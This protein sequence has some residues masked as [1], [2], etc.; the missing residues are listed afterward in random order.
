MYKKQS[1]DNLFQNPMFWIVAIGILIVVVSLKDED[2]VDES[3]MEMVIPNIP[4]TTFNYETCP[5]CGGTGLHYDMESSCYRCLGA[6]VVVVENKSRNIPF[7]G[8]KVDDDDYN[9]KQAEKYRKEAEYYYREAEKA[10][11]KGDIAL[12][13]RYKGKAETAER[14]ANEHLWRIRN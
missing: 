5:I 2:D 4:Q 13:N 8:N 14:L 10:Y 12:G 1:N 3:E 6:G 7:R 11:A 9:R